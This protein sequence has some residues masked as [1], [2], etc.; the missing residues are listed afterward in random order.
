MSKNPDDTYITEFMY[1]E[2]SKIINDIK[3]MLKGIRYI[4]TMPDIEDRC[5][6]VLRQMTTRSKLEDLDIQILHLNELLYRLMEDEYIPGPLVAMAQFERGK[7]LKKRICRA[8]DK[9]E[10]NKFDGIKGILTC[11]Y[12]KDLK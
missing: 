4:F 5:R 12:K 8:I 6:G 9:G 7:C 11:R 1:T 3:D 10:V 2:D